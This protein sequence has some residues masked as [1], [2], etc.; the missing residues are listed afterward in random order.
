[1]S[2]PSK[3][4]PLRPAVVEP[5]DGF[6][7]RLRYADGVEGEVDL[8]DGAGKGVFAAWLDRAFFGESRIGEWAEITWGNEIDLCP[9]ALDPEITG[10]SPEDIWPGL[11][12]RSA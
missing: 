3:P 2:H 1:M 5:R 10:E 7:I 11:K 4:D 8:S 9:H 12:A 6:R